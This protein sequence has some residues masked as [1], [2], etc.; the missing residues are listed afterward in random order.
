MKEFGYGDKVWTYSLEADR[1]KIIGPYLHIRTVKE[2]N[3]V[4][5]ECVDEGGDKVCIVN[6]LIA[7]SKD[8]AVYKCSAYVTEELA[9]MKKKM[10]AIE[11]TL[12]KFLEEHGE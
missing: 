12:C 3:R 9:T 8:E 2:E 7:A 4:L 11:D 5:Y 10:D 1:P 6:D